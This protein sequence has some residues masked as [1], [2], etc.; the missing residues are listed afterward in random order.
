MSRTDG[1]GID[2]FKRSADRSRDRANDALDKLRRDKRRASEQTTI[3]VHRK[4]LAR[5]GWRHNRNP[6]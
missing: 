6:S 3:E 2:A 1:P 5:E 4:V